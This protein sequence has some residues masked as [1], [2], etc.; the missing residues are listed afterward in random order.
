MDTSDFVRMVTLEFQ[1]RGF[2]LA[3]KLEPLHGDNE[4]EKEAEGQ[5]E[6]H[7]SERRGADGKNNDG[8]QTR[9]EHGDD[10]DVHAVSEQEEEKEK[11][12]ERDNINDNTN[13]SKEPATGEI[14]GN[15]TTDSVAATATKI[16]LKPTKRRI[17]KNDPKRP[18]PP[19]FPFYPST[20]RVTPQKD[21]K[22]NEMFQQL[23]TFYLRYGHVNIPP[24]N[25]NLI[26]WVRRQ[27]FLWNV[28]IRKKGSKNINVGTTAATGGDGGIS[29]ATS[30]TDLAGGTT[31]NSIAAFTTRLPLKP[32]NEDESA[33]DTVVKH[34]LSFDRICKLYSVGIGHRPKYYPPLAET[35]LL[36][37]PE[38]SASRADKGKGGGSGS[39]GK[40]G[41]GDKRVDENCGENKVNNSR[42][43]YDSEDDDD[44]TTQEEGTRG[45]LLRV[46][47]IVELLPED[48]PHNI[49][50]N[51]KWEM[52]LQK[53]R[54]YK[55]AHGDTY[56]PRK[57]YEELSRWTFKNRQQC[58][59]IM[60]GDFN[61]HLT[62]SRY[63]QLYELGFDLTGDE[64][65]VKEKQRKN[66]ER[67]LDR[68]WEEKYK[69]LL[70]YYK[71]H[72]NCD[73]SRTRDGKEK[74]EKLAHWAD[75]QRAKYKAK[76][77]GKNS[78][79]TDEQIKKLATIGFKFQ[80]Q[81][82]FDTR[83]NQLLE[84]KREH[85]HT[86]VPVFYTGHNKLGRWAKRMRDGIRNNEPWLDEVR[87][88]RLIGIDFDI[89]ARQVFDWGARK[90]KQQQEEE[91]S[92]KAKAARDAA[93]TMARMELHTPRLEHN[94]HQRH[95]NH[96]SA[97]QQQ[98]QQELHQSK[99]ENQP[100]HQPPAQPHLTSHQQQQQQ[101]PPQHQ[102]QHQHIMQLPHQP[103]NPVLASFTGMDVDR[104]AAPYYP[105]YGHYP[106]HP[107]HPFPP[108]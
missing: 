18:I 58:K 98:Q 92:R 23:Q 48:N 85:G 90:K 79:L 63:L 108:S 28:M 7:H 66:R 17:A 65:K 68:K 102:P 78:F 25:A 70:D 13:I 106:Y 104:A 45:P 69:E 40:G 64:Q 101:P 57:N 43:K 54:E 100:Q 5:K 62:K 76:M 99:H 36:I 9:G 91:D 33:P 77:K 97:Q 42:N 80:L 6:G 16:K 103:L 56:V 96:S 82:D 84:Y 47:Q 83:F 26:A 30:T 2:G 39:G 21:A 31:N 22:W 19:P 10:D 38:G 89:E 34:N 61:T 15:G 72:G 8:G 44:D 53:L 11:E 12:K 107:Y 50:G 4:K 75:T 73:V 95:Q 105:G 37:T 49:K 93:A 32:L 87:R 20:V 41:K 29:G 67:M 46:D 55:E 52:M 27:K 51:E 94:D 24:D 71:E 3:I 1:R 88:A 81:D 60:N 86:R 59:R 14:A 35:G 74:Y